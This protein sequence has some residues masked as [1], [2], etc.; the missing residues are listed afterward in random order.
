MVCLG[1]HFIGTEKKVYFTAL[2]GGSLQMS[3]GL[4]CCSRLSFLCCFCLVV[5]F[6]VEGRILL[7]PTIIVEMSICPSFPSVFA[8]CILGFVIRCM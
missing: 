1:E 3:V 8:S 5:L 7:S 6:V 2:S 4:E